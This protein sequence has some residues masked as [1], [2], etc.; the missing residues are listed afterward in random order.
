MEN[1]KFELTYSALKMFGKQLYSNVG[2]AISELVANG[3]DANAK[4]IYIA[5]NVTDKHHAIVEI[6]DDG[7]GMSPADIKDSYIKIGHNKRKGD[8][9]NK[10][11]GRKGIGK[12]A[13]LY[14]SDCF[15]ITTKKEDFKTSSWK[16]DVSTT[17]DEEKPEL[18][19]V[20]EETPK[21]LTCYEKMEKSK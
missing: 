21:T 12:L 4:N 18:I 9:Q 8:T 14:L 1:V 10:F 11:L 2:S 13:A 16:L 7:I 3:L 6:L 5:I 20:A 17:G 15:V 19:P